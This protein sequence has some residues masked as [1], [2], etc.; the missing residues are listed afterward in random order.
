MASATSYPASFDDPLSPARRSAILM[1]FLGVLG[2][3]GGVCV[4]ALGLLLRD[5]M[6][7][8]QFAAILR[9]HNIPLPELQSRIILVGAICCIGGFCLGALGFFVRKGNPA[10]IIAA[11]ALTIFALFVTALIFL[12]T[13]LA[14]NSHDDATLASIIWMLAVPVLLLVV[15]LIWLAAALRNVSYIRSLRSVADMM[16]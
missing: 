16:R 9:S 14:T 3:F 2:F 13:L 5:I 1:Y 7:Q 12:S 4:A 10:P 6:T 15:L 11:I 8:P